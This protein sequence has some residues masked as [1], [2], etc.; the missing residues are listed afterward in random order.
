MN[1]NPDSAPAPTPSRWPGR[2]VIIL[3]A[4][5]VGLLWTH[6]SLLQRQHDDILALREDVQALAESMDDSQ[7]PDSWDT[8]GIQPA[9]HP[10]RRHGGRTVRVA[11]Q[12]KEQPARDPDADS[13]DQA[14]SKDL[15]GSKRSA[16]DALAKA[17]D[18]QEKLSWTE[19]ARKADEQA[20][21]TAA[22]DTTMRWSWIAAG[23]LVV[24]LVARA[25]LRRRG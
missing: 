3:L 20:R 10:A 25:I 7:D 22:T 11:F 5:Q 18:T 16:L 6:G 19:N 1:P 9:R 2:A 17:R 8:T 21:I 4:V 24:A 14:A 12:Q 15:A 23:V 13:G